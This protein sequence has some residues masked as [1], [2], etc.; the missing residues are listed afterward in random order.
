MS[1]VP[2]GA[3]AGICSASAIIV[4]LGVGYVGRWAFSDQ[5]PFTLFHIVAIMLPTVIAFLA[6]MF[7]IW[8]VTAPVDES[9]WAPVFGRGRLSF[10]IGVVVMT[11][12]FLATLI[13]GLS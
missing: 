4:S 8:C 3:V 11:W 12:S 2:D 9:Q 5:I 6:F 10:L 13:P 7:A 1:K